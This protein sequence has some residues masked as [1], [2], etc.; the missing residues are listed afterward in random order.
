LFVVG[1]VLNAWKSDLYIY[2]RGIPV[3]PGTEIFSTGEGDVHELVHRRSDFEFIATQQNKDSGVFE[4]HTRVLSS[5]GEN[6]CESGDKFK[7]LLSKFIS[8]RA[9]RSIPRASIRLSEYPVE[10]G[11]IEPAVWVFRANGNVS[12][13]LAQDN[14][15]GYEVSIERETFDILSGRCRSL[16]ANQL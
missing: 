5:G 12:S 3:I 14:I 4:I 6:T 1:V 11:A 13:I 2:W 8:I 9:K 7:V 10:L 16:S 15:Q